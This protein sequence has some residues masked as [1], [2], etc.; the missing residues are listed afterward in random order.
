MSL[1]YVLQNL[2]KALLVIATGLFVA[3]CSPV[4]KASDVQGWPLKSSTAEITCDEAQPI[5]AKLDNG[6]TYGL[7]GT[8]TAREGLEPLNWDSGQFLPNPDPKL[9]ALGMAYAL[10]DTFN[11]AAEKACK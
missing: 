5:K 11:T 3:G 7:N 9:R 8:T 6:I 4:I 10:L 1:P 2:P